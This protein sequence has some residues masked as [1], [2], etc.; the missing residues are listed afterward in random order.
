MYRSIDAMLQCIGCDLHEECLVRPMDFGHSLSRTLEAS[1]EFRL[2]HGE[3][4]AIDCAMSSAIAH[5][6]G[7]FPYSQLQRVFSVY[8]DLCLPCTVS[9]L[10]S[11]TYKQA[12]RDITVHRDGFLRAPLPAGIGLAVYTSTITDDEIDAAFQI[13]EKFANNNPSVS[14]K[15]GGLGD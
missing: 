1:E 2:R 13:V 6:Q 14:W 12:V 7:I 15:C 10:S 3:A 9:G 11:R 5:V 4:V 8:A